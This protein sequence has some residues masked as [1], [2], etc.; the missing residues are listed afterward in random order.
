[1]AEAGRP[2]SER[3]ESQDA[4]FTLVEMLVA[5]ALAALIGVMLLQALQVTGTIAG[6]AARLGADEEVQA[7]RD[8]LRR[9]LGDLGGRRPNGSIPPL[10]GGADGLTGLV[11]ASREA[12]RAGETRMD[13]RVLPGETGLRLVETRRPDRASEGTAGEPVTE[14]LLDGLRGLEIRYF[15]PPGPRLAPLWTTEWTRRDA[16]PALVEVRIAFAPSD[17]RRWAPLLVPVGVRP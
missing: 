4:G 15:G 14:L 1:M 6:T 7:V 10:Q 16:L 3:A 11:A 12:E 5:L 9:A 2:R 17:R 8:H 13:L